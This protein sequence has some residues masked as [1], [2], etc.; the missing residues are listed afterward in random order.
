MKQQNGATASSS[1][2]NLMEKSGCAGK[3]ESSAYKTSP[4]GTY[5]NNIFPKLNNIKYLSY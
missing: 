3:T 2:P 5:L 1:Y 4:Q